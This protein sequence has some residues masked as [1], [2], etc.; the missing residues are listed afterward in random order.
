MKILYNTPFTPGGLVTDALLLYLVPVPL[1]RIIWVFWKGVH[2]L[3]SPCFLAQTERCC[4]Y[5]PARG[6]WWVMNSHEL[7]DQK[8]W[9]YSNITPAVCFVATAIETF[10]VHEKYCENGETINLI[11]SGTDAKSSCTQLAISSWPLYKNGT[12]EFPHES[13]KWIKS[14]LIYISYCYQAKVTMH[15]AYC[16]LPSVSVWMYSWAS[17]A[18]TY[19]WH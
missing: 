6:S 3:H 8:H 15:N 18:N 16:S 12:D 17:M 13:I 9:V 19:H 5:A 1:H 14:P 2:I 7:C 10:T 4:R 11:G